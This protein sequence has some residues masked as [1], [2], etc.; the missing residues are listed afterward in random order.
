MSKLVNLERKSEDNSTAFI[1][2]TEEDSE[3]IGKYE[4]MEFCDNESDSKQE[5][6]A[7][8]GESLEISENGFVSISISH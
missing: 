2:F 8:H 4:L 1:E 7:C 5:R 3:A 6:R